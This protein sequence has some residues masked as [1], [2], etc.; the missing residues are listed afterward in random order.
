MSFWIVFGI[1]AVSYVVAM[2]YLVKWMRRQQDPS[3]AE[4]TDELRSNFA[5]VQEELGNALGLDVLTER[6]NKILRS[7]K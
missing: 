7:I 1:A 4:L 6:I 2:W 3:Y 5:A